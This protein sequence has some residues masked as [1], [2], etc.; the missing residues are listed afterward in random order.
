MS[1]RATLPPMCMFLS[2]LLLSILAFC[3]VV[4]VHAAA[5]WNVQ[6]V[7]VNGE[8]FTGSC[9]I[10]IDS[11]NNPHIACTGR[12]GNKN[13]VMYADRG[14][15]GWSTR[16]VDLG[17]LFDLALDS[18]GNPHILYIFGPGGLRY[19]SWT[20]SNW[21]I[22]TVDQGFLRG[23]GSVALDS[24]G[25][26][27]IAYLDNFKVLKYASWLG[28]SWSIK[29]LDN[30]EDIWPVLS[31]E[32]GPNSTPYILYGLY[33]I[34]NSTIT[35]MM[36]FGKNS[37]WSIQTIA[38]NLTAY[39]NMVLD[40]MGHPHFFYQVDS[41]ESDDID[42]SIIEHA[43]WN[44]SAWNSQS[45]AL[46][47]VGF[48]A[49]DSHDNPSIAY[50]QSYEK[51]IYASWTGIAWKIQTVDS[52]ITAIAGCHLA[53]DAN[54]N[55]HIS[56]LAKPPGA[57]IPSQI[58]YVMYAT[59]AAS[60]FAPSIEVLSIADKLYDTNSIPLDFTIDEPPSQ[61]AY[62]LDGQENVTITGN[63][64]LTGLA[65]GDHDLVV[66][67]TDEEGNVGSSETIHFTIDVPFP[68]AL[69]AVVAILTVIT[70]VGLLLYFKKRKR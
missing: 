39:G 45:V 5:L 59:A 55:P 20:G 54:G 14:G 61:I 53:V 49:L 29:T 41:P 2:V 12:I 42:H 52:N 58:L 60:E 51:V 22:Q 26:P 7:D 19:A 6:T 17:R 30:A 31:L 21:N 66:Y 46:D 33:H 11:K 47:E 13:F 44:G 69:V 38:S 18:R 36:A 63:I 32:F 57:T 67:V 8:G 70:G 3:S 65:N 25:N 23:V 24:S 16:T 1:K 43:S 4:P 34:E 9:S 40:S 27:H 64:T 56:Y 62:S 37:S 48:L 10:V 28:S 35:A 50:I 15:S 68:A